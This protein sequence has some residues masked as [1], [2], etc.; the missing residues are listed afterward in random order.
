MA[1][2]LNKNLLLKGVITFVFLYYCIAWAHTH[3]PSH[4]YKLSHNFFDEFYQC[5]R[6]EFELVSEKICPENYR[7]YSNPNP[8]ENKIVCN[9]IAAC[10]EALSNA[11]G[12]YKATASKFVDDCAEIK[13]NLSYDENN[14]FWV[15]YWNI[16]FILIGALFCCTIIINLSSENNREHILKIFFCVF[17]SVVILINMAIL[18]S[19]YTGGYEHYTHYKKIYIYD[20]TH[21]STSYYDKIGPALRKIAFESL[22]GSNIDVLFDCEARASAQAN[23]VSQD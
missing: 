20:N 16:I 10:N 9:G 13:S 23:Q 4:E 3:L 21:G 17:I 8:V 11:G 12:I 18:Y 6:Y 1:Y 5:I 2:S 7:N 19:V 15:R 22:S 14:L